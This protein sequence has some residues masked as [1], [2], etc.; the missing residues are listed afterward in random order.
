[1][2]QTSSRL[3]TSTCLAG[4]LQIQIFKFV[5]VDS[6]CSPRSSHLISYKQILHTELE[7][8]AAYVLV[9]VTN[10]KNLKDN[11]TLQ[12][13]LYIYICWLL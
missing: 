8:V 13:Y 10:E 3:S 6:L 12:N 7:S 11:H 4:C 2:V 1:M 5:V 9:I